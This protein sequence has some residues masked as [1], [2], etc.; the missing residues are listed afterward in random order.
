MRQNQYGSWTTCKKCGLR[1]MY[2]TKGSQTGTSR[3]MGPDMHVIRLA[4]EELQLTCP[5]EQCTEKIM[6]GKLMEVKGKLLQM[7]ID[8]TMAV[9]MTLTEYQEKIEKGTR[10]AKCYL[11]PNNLPPSMPVATTAAP[12]STSQMSAAAEVLQA[13]NAELKARLKHAEETAAAMTSYAT[14]KARMVKKEPKDTSK[15][16]QVTASESPTSPQVISV[17]TS[18]EEDMEETRAKSKPSPQV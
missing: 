11:G 5:M 7:G 6:N 14:A 8:S 15:T 1:M 13:E 17:H 9:N 16:K 2:K 12:S 4:M 18:D 3:Q 10:H